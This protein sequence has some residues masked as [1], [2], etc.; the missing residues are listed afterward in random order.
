MLAGVFSCIKYGA[1]ASL[2]DRKRKLHVRVFHGNSSFE[3]VQNT[4][5]KNL[6]R[7]SPNIFVGNESIW[8][9]KEGSELV[10]STKKDFK[11]S[12]HFFRRRQIDKYESNF[13]NKG[14]INSTLVLEENLPNRNIAQY[15]VV[16]SS[17]LTIGLI[18]I[19]FF[20]SSQ[21]QGG[22][23]NKMNEVSWMLK[24]TQ[25]CDLIYCLTDCPKQI[26]PYFSAKE[27]AENSLCID[28]FFVNSHS[29]KENKLFVLRNQEGG[30]VLL[31][32]KNTLDESLDVVEVGGVDRF[33]IYQLK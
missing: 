13:E 14:R 21:S 29:S 17:G 4:F 18:R 33:S 30:Q 6:L 22:T 23:I 2:A 16:K 9:S 10:G 32:Q 19:G 11:F 12:T 31:S 5:N 1:F 26:F 3:A 7:S 24:N 8:C 15:E 27:L 25:G 20:N 28:H